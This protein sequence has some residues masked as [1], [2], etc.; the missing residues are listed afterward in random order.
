LIDEELL[1][2]VL[3]FI[4]VKI[5]QRNRPRIIHNFRI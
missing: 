2:M 1:Q 5:I 4:L 3:H